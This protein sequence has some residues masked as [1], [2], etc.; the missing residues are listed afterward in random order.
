MIFA[1]ENR[2]WLIFLVGSVLI[3]AQI[4]DVGTCLLYTSTMDENGLTV[5]NKL[6]NPKEQTAFEINILELM[7][8]VKQGE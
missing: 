3:F 5:R 4:I 6:L 2:I 8:A 1:A 7:R